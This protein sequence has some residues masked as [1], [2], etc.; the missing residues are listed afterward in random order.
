MGMLDCLT[1]ASVSL[2]YPDMSGDFSDG[3]NSGQ[4]FTPPPRLVI[5]LTHSL[6][7]GINSDSSSAAIDV[8]DSFLV[9]V[10]SCGSSY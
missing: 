8:N 9:D 3:Q 6:A 5:W 2:I 10:T 1:V 4:T 7:D